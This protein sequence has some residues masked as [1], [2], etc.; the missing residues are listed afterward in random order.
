LSPRA[1]AHR[2]LAGNYQALYHAG[3][4]EYAAGDPARA[5]ERLEAFSRLYSQPDQ[6]T[7]TAKLVLDRIAKGLPAEPGAGL[8]RH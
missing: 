1:P 3:I 2:V 5:K 6:F 7:Q 4:G 8:G